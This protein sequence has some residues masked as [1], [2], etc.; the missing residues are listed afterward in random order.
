MRIIDSK[1]KNFGIKV[2]MFLIVFN[3]VIVW[4]VFVIY[5]VIFK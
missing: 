2:F 5:F 4:F 3:D 1:M